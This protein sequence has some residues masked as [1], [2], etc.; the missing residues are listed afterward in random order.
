MDV[1]E[2]ISTRRT[3]FKFKPEPVPKEVLERVFEAGIWAPNHGVTEPWRFVVLGEKA[4]ATLAERYAEIQ[5]GKCADGVD[6]ETRRKAGDGGRAKFMS[7][8]TI[9]AV[10]CEQTGVDQRKQ[11]DYAATCCAIQNIQLAAWAESVGIQW[12]TGPITLEPETHRLLGLDPDTQYIVGFLYTG[13]PEVVP[14]PRRKPLS[15]VMTF[16]E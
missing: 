16:T 11:E 1:M 15:E 3:I 9:I 6:E 7:K 13:Y 5:I 10:A 14:T 2:A 8:P 4:K 12:S